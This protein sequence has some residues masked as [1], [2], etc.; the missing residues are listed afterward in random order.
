MF[1]HVDFDR[2]SG[3]SERNVLALATYY[4]FHRMLRP[5]LSLNANPSGALLEAAINQDEYSVALLLQYPQVVSLLRSSSP[6][7]DSEAF[8]VSQKANNPLLNEIF[9]KAYEYWNITHELPGHVDET[10]TD[11]D[12]LKRP[13]TKDRHDTISDG[14][15]PRTLIQYPA[16]EIRS[17]K[18]QSMTK[19]IDCQIPRIRLSSIDLEAFRSKHVMM[20]APAILIDDVGLFESEFKRSNLWSMDQLQAMHSSQ[21]ITVSRI[22]YS[23]LFSIEEVIFHLYHVD[24]VKYELIVHFL[25]NDN[26]RRILIKFR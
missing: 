5:L 18:N 9:T 15:Y 23:S 26:H 13:A 19:L 7:P 12:I 16:L 8:I 25:E 17:G 1:V 21:R 14:G 11:G 20:A 24:I 3:R 2:R 6:S 22:P 10:S 4:R